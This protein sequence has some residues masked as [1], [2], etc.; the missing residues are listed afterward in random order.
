[1]AIDQSQKHIQEVQRFWDERPCNI[2]HSP[3]PFGT[4]EYFEEVKKR[5][6]F[7]EGHIRQFVEFERW[8][9]KTVLEIGCGIGTDTVEFARAGARITATELSAKS[10]EIAK[11]R[12]QVYGLQGTF[13]LANAE[14]L[15]HALLPAP[16]DLIY[17]FG[18]IHHTPRP[19]RALREL[20]KYTHPKTELRI[21]LYAKWSWKVLWIILVF[22]KGQFWR[23][24]ELVAQ[25]SE[26]QFGS[27]VTYVYSK[28]EARR[29]LEECGFEVTEIKKY[30]IFPYQIPEYR[31]YRYRK[32][33]YFCWMPQFLFDMIQRLF[34]WQLLIHA[35]P[36]L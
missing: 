17:S 5:R 13:L 27:P 22:G 12:F 34:G 16:F 21:M 15:S 35:V 10:L 31:Q 26:A 9:D 6:Y 33:W 18:V 29:L 25:N 28:S 19:D 20:K 32:V 36:K 23:W 14:E 1:M 24:K 3:K 11:Q 4:L 2:R 7:V 8:K 30:F